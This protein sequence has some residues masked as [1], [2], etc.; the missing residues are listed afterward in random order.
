MI[1]M[2]MTAIFHS[3][4]N[5]LLIIFFVF[6][7]I[8][9]KIM[10]KTTQTKTNPNNENTNKT[11]D[12]TTKSNETKH[13]TED[14]LNRLFNQQFTYNKDFYKDIVRNEFSIR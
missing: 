4:Q 3:Y 8:I 5:K 1:M 9:H 7:N 10:D 12:E 13:D 6:N 14:T 2:I 11:N